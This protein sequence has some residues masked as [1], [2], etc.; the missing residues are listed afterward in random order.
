M[1]PS[2]SYLPSAVVTS[3]SFCEELPP[4]SIKTRRSPAVPGT[5][6]VLLQKFEKGSS[7]IEKGTFRTR[8]APFSAFAVS[9]YLFRKL[10]GKPAT[11]HSVE[12]R[13]PLDD[14]VI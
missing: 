11:G 2:T 7:H 4:S 9:L 6:T 5:F 1:L 8:N 14:S 10:S 13:R 12:T 3:G